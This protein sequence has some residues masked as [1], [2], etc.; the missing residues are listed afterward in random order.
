[1]DGTTIDSSDPVER[2]VQITGGSTYTVSIPKAWAEAHEITSGSSVYVHPFTDRL[3]IVH[4]EGDEP[5]CRARINIEAAG[6]D[7]LDRQI[8]AAY[9]AGSDEIVVES[10]TRLSTSDRRAVSQA[11][12]DLVG[13]EITTETKNAVTAKT[14]LDSTEV[15]LEET[16]EQIRGIALSMHENAIE[17]VVTDSEHMKPAHIINRD[18]EVD[19]LFALVSRQFYRQLADIREQNQYTAESRKTF[20]QFRTARQL[21]RIADHAERIATV[22]DKQTEP[23]ATTVGSEFQTLG[24]DAR[25]VVRKALDGKTGEAMLRCEDVIDRLAALDGRLYDGQMNDTYLYGR[26]IAS[27]RRTAECG[28]NISDSITLSEMVASC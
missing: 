9:A 4:P 23:P 28:S 17:T 26:V 27:I 15:S 8:W 16:I 18:D 10:E 22:A 19:R 2:K 1:M 11:I 20:T 5:P 7:D 6:K 12:S 24:T 13:I 21:E 3:V 14:L 25:R